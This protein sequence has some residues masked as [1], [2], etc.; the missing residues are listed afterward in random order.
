MMRTQTVQV[1]SVCQ[2]SACLECRVQMRHVIP[3]A[4]AGLVYVRMKPILP[5]LSSSVVAQVKVSVFAATKLMI[6][7]R[8]IHAQT[9]AQAKRRVKGAQEAQ[10][11]MP[12][13][14][15][16]AVFVSQASVLDDILKE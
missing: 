5:V 3:T 11:Q 14:C 4:T 6:F 15:A 1:M 8:K 2:G 10:R 9:F 13:T 16:R 12:M 7:Q